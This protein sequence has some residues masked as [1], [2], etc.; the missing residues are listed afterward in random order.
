[1]EN[2]TLSEKDFFGEMRNISQETKKTGI[3]LRSVNA[4]RYPIKNVVNSIQKQL[5]K[6]NIKIITRKKGFFLINL[7]EYFTHKISAKS[8]NRSPSQINTGAIKKTPGIVIIKIYVFTL[9]F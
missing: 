9:C 2:A 5:Y 8:S 1:M 7:F 3:V 6:K 4:S